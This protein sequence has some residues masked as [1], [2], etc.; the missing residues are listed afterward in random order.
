MYMVDSFPIGALFS[1]M[2]GRSMGLSPC[3]RRSPQP[4]IFSCGSWAEGA[5][6]RVKPSLPTCCVVVYAV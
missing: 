2:A 3:V 6:T 1:I 5:D 4:P